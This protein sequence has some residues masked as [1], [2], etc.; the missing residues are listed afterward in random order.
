[1]PF[2]FEHRK[3]KHVLVNRMLTLS[4]LPSSLL[5]IDGSLESRGVSDMDG[6]PPS[7]S[8]SVIA[9]ARAADIFGS[10]G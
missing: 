8:L 4:V 1:M 7:S 6:V 2:S 5:A 10:D 9:R 3:W